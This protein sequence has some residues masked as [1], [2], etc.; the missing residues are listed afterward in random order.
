MILNISNPFANVHEICTKKRDY[1]WEENEY[2]L[3]VCFA[4]VHNLLARSFRQDT[5]F[6]GLET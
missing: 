2:K 5:S 6:L 1:E 4:K 3:V